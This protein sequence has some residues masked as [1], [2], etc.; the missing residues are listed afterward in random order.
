MFY[1]SFAPPGHCPSQIPDIKSSLQF[2]DSLPIQMLSRVVLMVFH[3]GIELWTDRKSKELFDLH[4][5]IVVIHENT[6]MGQKGA[7]SSACLSFPHTFTDYLIICHLNDLLRMS[8]GSDWTN[9]QNFVFRTS[10]PQI[11]GSDL[12]PVLLGAVVHHFSVQAN[13]LLCFSG[14]LLPVDCTQAKMKM[15]VLACLWLITVC[16]GKTREK[17]FPTVCL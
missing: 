9:P 10:E 7:S 4:F 2:F 12:S 16:S 17:L 8:A 3:S 15:F 14:L 6:V 13:W 5:L 1:C 11:K